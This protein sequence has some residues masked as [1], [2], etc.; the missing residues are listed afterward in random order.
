V[1]IDVAP[2]D[3][4]SDD[5][6]RA[7]PRSEG[8][9]LFDRYLLLERIGDGGTGEV[10]RVRHLE[11]DSERALK[12]IKPEIARNDEGWMRFGREA[13]LM[14]RIDHP[15]AVAVYDVG[16]KQS[17]G[18]I[19][20]ESVR[21]RSLADVLEGR[22]GR[23]MPLDWTAQVL[24]QLCSVLQEAHGC[25]DPRTG[26]PKP[27]LHR[28]LKPSHLML[29]DGKPPGED[30]KVLDFGIARMVEDE[31]L[32]GTPAYMSP[33]RIR[34]GIT[35]EGKG[36][37]DGR[38]DLYST[39]VLLYQL[40]TGSLPFPKM[41]QMALLGAHLHGTPLPMKEANPEAEVPAEVDRVVMQCLEKDP[42]KRP[43]TAREL[44]ETYRAAI[45][46]TTVLAR[47]TDRI[48]RWREWFGGFF[49]RP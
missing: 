33:E 47:K 16:L 22:H 20:M 34:G 6:W 49:R 13:R 41:D 32:V 48:G 44:A 1:S 37:I 36:D 28:D 46:R 21:G 38:S 23:P 42:V 30:L 39:G 40:L 14:A 26:L 45:D 15:N 7:L 35:K 24:D 43:Q 31:D 5:A 8:R 4:D 12:L 3:D 2:D 25:V 9:V 29:V 17:V 18:Y 10:W 11:R 27:I 19:E